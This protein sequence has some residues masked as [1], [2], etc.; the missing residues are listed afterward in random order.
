MKNT[1]QEAFKKDEVQEIDVALFTI[2]VLLGFWEDTN[3]AYREHKALIWTRNPINDLLSHVLNALVD[4]QFIH[5]TEEPEET[6]TWNPDIPHHDSKEFW[7]F[8]TLPYIDPHTGK[9]K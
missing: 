6:W 4:N 7:N 5:Y 8:S 9:E 1:I 2:G 3:E